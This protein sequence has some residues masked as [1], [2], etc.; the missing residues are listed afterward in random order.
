[1]V[2]IAEKLEMIII[3]YTEK[4]KYFSEAEFLFKP[5]ATKWSKKEVIGH[6]IDSA[7]NNIR[8]FVVAQYELKPHIVYTQDEWVAIQQY[9]NYPLNNLIE[10]WQLL[11]GHIC[12][13]LKTMQPEMYHRSCDTG[14]EKEEL[15]SLE[16]L[17]SDYVDH[18]IHHLKQIV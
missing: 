4:I 12:I 5:D 6:L 11:N 2:S 15:H 13:I 3:E 18:Q 17:A 10:L 1:M 16:F 14:K 8:R 9:Q 7:Q